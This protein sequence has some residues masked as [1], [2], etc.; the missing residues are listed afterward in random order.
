[1]KVLFCGETF[2][3]AHKILQMKAPDYEVFNC[4]DSQVIDLARRVDVLIPLMFRLSAEIIQVTSAKIIHQWGVGLEG[5]DV[6][7]ATAGGIPV[8]NVPGDITLNAD[9]T[10]EHAIFLMMGLA[11]RIFEC[12]EA[13]TSGAWGEPMGTALFG[14]SALIVGLGKVGK[15]LAK[16]LTA[17]GMSVSAIRR[18]PDIDFETALGIRQAGDMSRLP[19]LAAQADFVISTISLT[20]ET[21]RM[22][23]HE[24]FGTMKPEAFFINVS[25]GPVAH[26]Q[27]LIEAL[28][29]NLIAGAGLDVFTN[30]PL[31]PE[32]PL[33]K[34]P[35]VFATPHV[36]GATRQNYEGIS[37]AVLGNLRRFERGEKPHNCV[38]C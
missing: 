37:E 26:E 38:N 17:L 27:D 31:D 2:P 16:K 14:E 33:L 1:M 7:A 3:R 19:E 12:R 23:N 25:R 6:S 29:R 22:F 34:L 35:T 15:A 21:R 13:F 20:P 30:E 9:S 24:F 11:R 18:R 28:E 36:A 8:C 10:A 5:V 4:P 32:S